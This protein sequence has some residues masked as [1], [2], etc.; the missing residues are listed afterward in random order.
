[1]INVTPVILRGGAGTRLWPPSRAGFPKQFLSV[2]GIESLFQQAAKRMVE[3]SA[4]DIWGAKSLIVTGQEHRSLAAEQLREGGIELDAALLEPVGW[5][6][7]PALS[8]AAMAA[9]ADGEDP[10]HVVIPVDQSVVNTAAF[11]QAMQKAIREAGRGSI[12]ILGAIA[13]KY[14]VEKPNSDTAQQYLAKGSYYWIVGM[15]VLNAAV[16]L[17]ALTASRP[18]IVYGAKAAWNGKTQD[19]AFV[20]S[21]KADFNAVLS[22]YIDYAVLEHCPSGDLPIK[23]VPLDAGWNDL[24]ARDAVRSV[25]PK[26]DQDNAYHGDVLS[27]ASGNTL[28]HACSPPVSLVG[29][30]DLIIIETSDVVRVAVKARSQGVKH[31]ASQL[32]VTKRDERI[33]HRK[34]HRRWG[35]GTTV[36]TRAAA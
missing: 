19:G 31:I 8:L 17:Q 35:C 15:F 21:G 22:E 27:T 9:Q 3:L 4:D 29:V 1:M 30:E 23:M 34:V 20:L 32:Q 12:V 25:L 28:V 13:V 2:T 7:A 36:S 10:V 18:D 11:T 33:L 26:D 6:N 14:F 24:G 5:N 16:W